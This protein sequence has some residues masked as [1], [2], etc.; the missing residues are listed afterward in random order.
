MNIT[1]TIDR[2]VARVGSQRKLAELLGLQEQNISG[3]K[4]GRPCSYQKHAQIAAAAGMKEEAVRI[5]MEG[6]ASSLSDDLEHEAEVKA[7]IMA[8]LS[9]FPLE[10]SPHNG[11][12]NESPN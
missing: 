4:K 1:Q 3:Y 2:A 11:T 10:A 5:L 9:A 8:I 12:R 6:M 7:G